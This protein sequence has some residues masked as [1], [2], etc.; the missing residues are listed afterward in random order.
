MRPKSLDDFPKRVAPPMVTGVA[1]RFEVLECS[2]GLLRVSLPPERRVGN[3]GVVWLGARHGEKPL[4]RALVS[5]ETP[6]AV[7]PRSYFDTAQSPYASQE[8]TSVVS[9]QRRS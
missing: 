3:D 2:S 5:R 8:R 1:H 6:M 7:P 9:S 4:R